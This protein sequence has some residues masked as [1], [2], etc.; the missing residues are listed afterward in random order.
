MGTDA[1]ASIMTSEE[2]V[3]PLDMIQRRKA[4]HIR[5]CMERQVTNGVSTGFEKVM[6]I[7]QSLPE[8]DFGSIDTSV[9]LLGKRL[10]APILITAMT[11]GCPE[12]KKI[13]RNLAE[14]AE[15]VGVAM[16]LGS[17]RAM[18]KRPELADT[19]MVRDVAPSIL[20]MGNIGIVQFVNGSRAKEFAAA[21][22]LGCDAIAVHLNPL[23]E[24][25][26]PEGDRNWA[27]CATQLR[28]ICSQS[29]LPIV[30]KETGAGIS[31]ETARVLEMSGTAAID[32][33]GCGGTNFALVESHRGSENGAVFHDWGIPTAC[34]LLEV[35]KA[36]GLPIIC[37][38][39]MINGLDV[40][41]SVAMGATVAGLARPL[42]KPATES[43]D[44]VERVLLEYVDQLKTAMMLVGARN[45]EGLRHARYVMTGFVKEWADQRV[46][47]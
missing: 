8:L 46:A 37:S 35:K 31:Y 5:I 24:A 2:G 11:G 33:S 34:S 30:A 3:N 22:E 42:L 10:K 41:K 21:R 36:T 12:A 26:Q 47:K 38:G 28:E 13:N 39:G 1:T 15:R 14:A 19:Y 40:A 18:L 20:L 32:I 4:E 17:Q 9:E 25:V 43:A 6:L 16:G 45:I 27:G 7:H 44:A 29:E 23:Q